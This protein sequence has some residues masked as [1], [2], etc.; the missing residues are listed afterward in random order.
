[1][2]RSRPDAPGTRRLT[3]QPSALADRLQHNLFFIPFLSVASAVILA[4]VLVGT[5]WGSGMFGTSLATTVESSRSLLSAVATGSITAVSLILS[6]M[7]VSVS[8][9]TGQ[10]SPRTTQNLLGDRVLQLTIG[11][12]LGTVAY[13]LVALRSL[14]SSVEDSDLPDLLIMLAIVAAVSELLL[15]VASSHRLATR[16]RISNVIE[17]LTKRTCELIRADW[18]STV[19]ERP[20]RVANPAD[21]TVGVPEPDRVADDRGD[22]AADGGQAVTSAPPSSSAGWM[23]KV[24]SPHDDP[25]GGWSIVET[26]RGGWVQAIDEALIA[27]VVNDEAVDDEAEVL[28]ECA[29]GRFVLPGASLVRVSTPELDDAVTRTVRRAVVIGPNRTLQHDAAFGIVQLEDIGLR[30]LSAG[31][32]DANTAREIALHLG[33]IL[34]ELHRHREPA[35]DLVIEGR[36]LRRASVPTHLELVDASFEQM[37]VAAVGQEAVTRTFADVVANVRHEIDR[38]GLPGPTEG[39]DRLLDRLRGD[40][41]RIGEY[42]SRV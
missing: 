2:Q 29:V 20:E 34:L 25:T 33:E 7:L 17:D 19:D 13:S 22:S 9:T 14:D 1:M 36:R 11:V 39:L 6:L 28:I 18:G 42:S 38:Q 27:R 3:W 41:D 31:I 40:L 21:R 4:L 8:L 37:R 15:L 23:R 12:M 32:N 35:T 24:A 10:F 30:A 26:D 16:L 5:G